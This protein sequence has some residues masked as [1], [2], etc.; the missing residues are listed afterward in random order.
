VLSVLLL[1]ALAWWRGAF[2]PLQRRPSPAVGFTTS[3]S[4]DVEDVQASLGISPLGTPGPT[5]TFS[6]TPVVSGPGQFFPSQGH[7]HI[8]QTCPPPDDRY[9][10]FPY[11]SD[12][13]TSGPH[14]ERFPTVFVS[15][16]PL[17]KA[18]LVHILEHTNVL[19]LYN[20]SASPD[21][22]DRLHRT[23]E[24]YDGRFLYL[25]TPTASGEDVSEKLQGVQG[26]FVAPYPEM[27]HTIALVAWTRLDA[28]NSYDQGR[29][30]LFVRAW[31]GNVRNA[32]Q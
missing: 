30:D 27:A 1:L 32:R 8:A 13:P 4:Q 3:A 9:D 6:L 19:L 12:P 11:D 31:L 15:T 16:A 14:L 26:V 22:V 20:R 23:A 28:F 24:T 17:P 7:C 25:Q 10:T 18:I 29:I 2:S 5:P 21:V